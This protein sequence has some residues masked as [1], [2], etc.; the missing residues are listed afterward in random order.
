MSNIRY[1]YAKCH[2]GQLRK[3]VEKACNY[4][5]KRYDFER[6][7]H[8]IDTVKFNSR[9]GFQELNDHVYESQLDSEVAFV[10]GGDHSISIGS[11]AGSLKHHKDN[12][13]VVWVDTHADINTVESS[14]S[15][16]LHGM[17]L[18]CLTGIENYFPPSQPLLDTKNLVYLGLR[19][20]DEFEE[21]VIEDN[22]IKFMTTSE[23]NSDTSC[24]D[25]IKINTDNIHLS[26]DVDVLDPKIMTATGTPVEDGIDL[27]KLE[28][29]VDWT[30]DQGNVVSIDLVEFNPKLGG[31][32]FAKSLETYY[33][34]IDM[35]HGKL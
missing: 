8:N 31:K 3:G 21:K 29:I 13:S 7:G 30:F 5:A 11:V 18:S 27:D 33:K 34:L 9:K 14:A 35:L 26:I 23:L 12:L 24:L 32:E 10:V 25:W 17:P 22:K 20:V 15:G 2:Q 4:I 6:A 19:D 1:I 16:S 28:E